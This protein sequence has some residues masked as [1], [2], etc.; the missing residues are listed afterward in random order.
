MTRR[1]LPGLAIFVVLLTTIF[2]SVSSAQ[3]G[4]RPFRWLGEGYGPGFNRCN[5]GPNS[6]YY[7][8]YSSHNSMLISQLPQFQNHNFQSSYRNNLESRPVY[9]GV[10]FSIYAAPASHQNFQVPSSHEVN[11]DSF[12]PYAPKTKP[13]ADTDKTE[14]P[15]QKTTND[16]DLSRAKLQTPSSSNQFQ[17][18]YPLHRTQS[19][20]SKTSFQ[21]PPKSTK[22]H[23]LFDPFA[24]N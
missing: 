14:A 17:L 21:Q 7:S 22:Q 1:H 8:P 2:C 6:D 12:I 3:F 11:Q 5:P 10:P 24:K 4:H 18:T 23:D 16:Q 9:R 15:K 20:F 19:E 13:S